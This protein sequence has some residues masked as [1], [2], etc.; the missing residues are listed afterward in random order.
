MSLEH[1][2]LSSPAGTTNSPY[3]FDEDTNRRGHELTQD[4][5]E[6]TKGSVPTEYV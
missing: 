4:K 2:R 1:K 6:D 5:E 3:G